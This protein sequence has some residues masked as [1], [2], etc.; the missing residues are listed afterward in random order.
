VHFIHPERLEY[1]WMAEAP[2]LRRY[3]GPNELQSAVGTLPVVDLVFMEV[4]ARP[5]QSLLEVEWVE[6][7]MREEPRLRALVAQ[8]RLTDVKQ[9]D[10][11]LDALGEHPTVRGIRDIIQWEAPGYCC[12]PAYIEGAKIAAARGLHL[13]LCLFPTQLEDALALVKAVP[14]ARFVLNHCAKPGIRTKAWQPW[15]DRIA[16]IA[17]Y[18]NLICKISGLLTE[19]DHASWQPHDILP[20]IHHVIEHFGTRR[21]M[22]G[23]DWPVLT[24]AGSY[25]Q[26][27]DVVA[28]AVTGWSQS[29]LDDFL[30]GNA[31][32][33]YQLERSSA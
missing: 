33:F 13:E 15:A 4:S 23:G 17:A 30:Y 29:E 14:D 9:R 21:L 32:R 1:P 2:E 19:A 26:W 31:A 28:L 18:P 3:F 27:F 12:Q 24:L 5:E 10:R 16:Q 25:Q 8:A 7:L 20:Y 11:Q 22:Y 6:T